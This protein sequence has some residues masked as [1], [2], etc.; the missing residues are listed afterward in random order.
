MHK[1][2][3][4]LTYASLF[5]LAVGIFT[6][7]SISAISHVLLIIPGVYFFY[8]DFIKK[9]KPIELSGSSVF[10]LLMIG[11]II[12]SVIFNLDILENP[13]KNLFKIKYFIIPWLGVFAV[14]RLIDE[15]LSPKK[16]NILINTFLIATTVA[17][18]S[19]LIGLYT[20]FNPIKMKSA[21]HSTRACGLYGMYMTYGYGVS[22]FAVLMTSLV[23]LKKNIVNRP[24]LYIATL[25]G[26]VGTVL[27]FAR[28]GWLGYIAGVGAF[29]FKKNIKVFLVSI[30]V[31]ITLV[32]TAFFTSST[33]KDMVSNR[34]TSNDQRIAFYLTAYAA[35]KERPL[36]GWGYRNFEPNVKEIKKKYNIAYPDFGG[37]AHNNI[38][39]HLASTGIVG[40]IC[41]LGFFVTWLMESY[42]RKDLTGILTFPF[43][44][45]FLTSGLF[46]YTFGDG[47]NLFLLMGVWTIF[48]LKKCS[49]EGTP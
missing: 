31:L 2:S 46:Q 26:L 1:I 6:S 17:T 38:L 15:D 3:L 32:T 23:F 48:R 49:S 13:L 29:F 12:L 36:F 10:L 9:E 45:S 44:V 22:L 27:S 33:V 42:K 8:K 39:E 4:K 11:S 43:V 24:L 18:I 30:V 37:H 35:F 7:V 25:F 19:G 40:F 20:G 14:Q 41:T 16:K 47:E 21:C 28:G 34:S 5:I